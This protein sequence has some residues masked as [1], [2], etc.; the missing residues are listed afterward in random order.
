MI[1]VIIPVYNVEK[2]I[3]DLIKSLISQSFRDFEVI[4]V[5]DGSTD[6]SIQIAERMLE[7]TDIIYKI[8]QQ[9]NKGQSV[10][11]NE[12]I[13]YSTSEWIV[14]P[15]ADDVLHPDYL[16]VLYE[17]VITYNT[18][19][20]FCN[21]KLIKDGTNMFTFDKSK[22]VVRLMNTFE[23]M[24]RFVKG[25]WI[26]PWSI[27]IN[28]NFF[29][30]KNLWFDEESRYD[31]DLIFITKLICEVDRI[32]EIHANLY[33]YRKRADSVLNGSS[34]IRI[35]NG[36]N[37]IFLLNDYLTNKANE[38]ATFFQKYG[39]GNLVLAKARNCAKR[40]DYE[41][42]KII[43]D[44]LDAKKYIQKYIKAAPLLRKIAALMFIFSDKL[45]YYIAK[46]IY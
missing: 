27:I 41:N 45:F 23:C 22:K 5:D 29:I 39:F 16:K 8:V 18:D 32:Y 35:L 33:N 34:K 4:I 26:G 13:K 11:R 38:S 30:N 19:V 2:Y 40:F 24:R 9:K 15:D 17:T 14:I 6:N 31:E 10:A 21:F 7:S 28:R 36:Y 20:A 1:S 43:T 3:E 42:Y 37:R 46:K 25:G 12:G 44:E